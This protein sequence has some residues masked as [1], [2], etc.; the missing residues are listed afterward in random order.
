MLRLQYPRNN[1]QKG[2]SLSFVLILC[3]FLTLVAQMRS[4]FAKSEDTTRWC[5]FILMRLRFRHSVRFI[6]FIT[7][8]AVTCLV[9]VEFAR[10]FLTNGYLLSA[11][12]Y[13]KRKTLFECVFHSRTTTANL[14][15]NYCKHPRLCFDHGQCRIHMAYPVKRTFKFKCCWR[16]YCL[17]T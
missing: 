12:K 3:R 6:G 8:T 13:S 5:W 2:C 14:N 17:K 15:L 9:R 11:D 4:E 10:L 1:T 16:Y 7:L